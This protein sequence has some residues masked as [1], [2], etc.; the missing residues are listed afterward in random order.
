MQA[1]NKLSLRCFS[2]HFSVGAAFTKKAFVCEAGPEL[3]A[4]FSRA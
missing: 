4:A 2:L 3:M 1:W